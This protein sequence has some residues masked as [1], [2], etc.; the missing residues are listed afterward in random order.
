MTDKSRPHPL[1]NYECERLLSKY[2]FYLFVILKCR[3]LSDCMS[4]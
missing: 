1:K 4:L 3:R 2:V